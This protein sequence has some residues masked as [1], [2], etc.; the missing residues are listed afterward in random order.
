MKTI[1]TRFEGQGVAFDFVFQVRDPLALG[2]DMRRSTGYR[3][4]LAKY[5][6]LE[7][8]ARRRQ[9]S[10]QAFIDWA[11]T[12]VLEFDFLDVENRD[13][14]RDLAMQ[15]GR[16]FT[17]FDALNR[18]VT[19][20]RQLVTQGKLVLGGWARPQNNSRHSVAR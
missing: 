4:D 12:Q 1:L 2:M 16:P 10:L 8:E 13:F 6:R 18:C 15:L 5:A 3:A 17:I 7:D 11:L 20:I 14:V 9:W 19:E